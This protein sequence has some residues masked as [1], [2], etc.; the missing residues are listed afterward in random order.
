MIDVK[1]KIKDI[2]RNA[3]LDIF[4]CILCKLN[5]LSIQIC[6][7]LNAYRVGRIKIKDLR[8]KDILK[9]LQTDVAEMFVKNH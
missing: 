5:G 6:Q 9:F 8:K 7:I 1:M 2:L 4:V 3:L